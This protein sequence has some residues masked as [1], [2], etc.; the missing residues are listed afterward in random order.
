MKRFA[1]KMYLKPGCE[2]E[3]AKRHAAIWPELK[4]M[5]K[6]Q[7]VGNY[8]IFW[9]KETNILFAYQACSKEGQLRIPERLDQVSLEALANVATFEAVEKQ[10]ITDL[11]RAIPRAEPRDLANFAGIIHRR[12]DG[13]WASRHKDD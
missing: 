10:I 4:Q 9:D 1:F 12:L 3:Y 8:S 5:I 13:Y 2:K 7:G 11:V 6:E